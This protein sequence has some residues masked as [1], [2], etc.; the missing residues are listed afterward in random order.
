MFFRSGKKLCKKNKATPGS[1]GEPLLRHYKDG[2][3]H[4]DYDRRLTVSSMTTFLR[5]PTGDLPW[6]ED[7]NGKDVVHVNDVAVRA[8][9][10]CAFTSG[11]ANL[12]FLFI[13]NTF[14]DINCVTLINSQNNSS[15]LK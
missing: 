2:E 3:Y 9:A 1:G 15:I 6:D 11:L 4:K 7:D 13:F 10:A 8:R 12:I 14:D 5:D